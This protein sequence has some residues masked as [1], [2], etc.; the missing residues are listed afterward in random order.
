MTTS[1]RRP[2]PWETGKTS[3]ALQDDAHDQVVEDY[4]A[5]DQEENDGPDVDVDERTIQ[6]TSLD[7]LLD[8][9]LEGSGD[10]AE[11]PDPCGATPAESKS[12]AARAVFVGATRRERYAEPE[13]DQ[14]AYEAEKPPLLTG[15]ERW[16][17]AGERVAAY[18]ASAA[19]QPGGS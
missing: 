13:L 17:A 7:D 3:E 11:S 12:Q 6:P 19:S 15:R 9:G 10:S 18:V 1:G 5:I 8:S 14:E 2:T 4:D 16:E